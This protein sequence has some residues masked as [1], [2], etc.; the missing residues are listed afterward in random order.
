MP[1]SDGNGWVRCGLGHRHWGRFGAAGLLAYVPSAPGRASVLLQRRGWQGHHGGTWGLP[2][3]AVDS[4]ES[5]VQAALRE[6]AEECAVPPELIRVQGIFHDD[7]G[8]WAYDSVIAVADAAFEVYPAS[9]ETI[10]AAWVPADE[11]T[12]LTLHPGLTAHWETLAGALEPVTLIVDGANVMGSRPD[13]WWR[14]R[15][16]AARRLAGQLAALAQTGLTALPQSAGG[17]ALSRWFPDIVLVVEGAARSA[18]DDDHGAPAGGP[19]ASRP[20]LQVLAAPGSGDDAIADLA[21]RLPGRRIVVTADRELRRRAEQAGASV[22]GPGWLL[23]LLA[24]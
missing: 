22:A 24:S 3:G 23:G 17:P 6:A 5:P 15:A 8:G 19:A 13:G 9:P 11:A 10:A 20:R 21:G 4:H 14:D 12:L 2:G 7:H 18:A 16:G 1:G